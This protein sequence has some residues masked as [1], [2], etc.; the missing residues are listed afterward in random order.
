MI[1]NQFNGDDHCNNQQNDQAGRAEIQPFI[2]HIK[3]I[4]DSGGSQNAD[5]RRTADIGFDHVQHPGDNAGNDRWNHALEYGL[6]EV[7]TG[8]VECLDTG[9]TCLVNGFD[10]R[11][12]PTDRM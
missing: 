3:Q 4:T 9:G 1:G 6:D 5:E 2:I 8:C 10:K 12:G 7:R 11:T